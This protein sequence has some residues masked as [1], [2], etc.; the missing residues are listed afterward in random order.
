MHE[1]MSIAWQTVEMSILTIKSIWKWMET[2]KIWI[3]GLNK[4]CNVQMPLRIFWKNF[5][6]I[7]ELNNP[8]KYYTNGPKS[9]VEEEKEVWVLEWVT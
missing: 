6:L 4:L 5:G 1:K 7:W 2:K 9:S 3:K 8:S